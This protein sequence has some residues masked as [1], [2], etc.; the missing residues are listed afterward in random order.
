MGWL[1]A[2]RQW[3]RDRLLRRIRLDETVWRSI[4]ACHPYTRTLP[5]ADLG[6]LRDL[7]KL[8]LHSKPIHGA[9]GHAVTD[10]MRIAI[11]TQACVLI[12]ELGLRYYRGWSEV[13]VYPDEFVARYE[14]TDEDGVVHQVAEPMSGEA[15]AGGP[16][17]LSWADAE[18]AGGMAPYN[19]VMHEFAHKLD[20][21]NGE[22]NGYPP[23]HAGMSR[24]EWSSAFNE[25][26]DDFCRRIDAGEELAIDDYASE[27]PAEFFAVLSEV[28]F[29][30]PQL[31]IDLYPAVYRQLVRFYRQDPA[32]LM[33]RANAAGAVGPALRT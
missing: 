4:V 12:L 27:T 15:W 1:A 6:R 20:M 9:G 29:E 33:A 16:V 17:I 8:F 13:I 26:Y 30:Q 23:L 3:R 28:F 19:V 24:Q 10:E 25:A 14:Y 21:L 11:A 22:A 18:E 5:E 7:V 2:L 32:A 31:L